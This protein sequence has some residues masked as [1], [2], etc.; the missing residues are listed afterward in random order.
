MKRIEKLRIP[1]PSKKTLLFVV[2]AFLVGIV[3]SG[4]ILGLAFYR[5]GFLY[6]EALPPVPSPAPP[7]L[8]GEVE[9]AYEKMKE[10]PT[11]LETVGRMVIYTA[12]LG[13]EVDDVD[14]MI[15]EIRRI[16][17]DV[18]GF[19][20]GVSTS[21]RDERKVGIITI[22]VPQTDFY[23]IIWQIE[24]LGEVESKE[25]RGED[26][27]EQYIDL[28]ARLNNLQRQEERLLEIL[29]MATTVDEVLR[30]ES[31]LS[32]VRGE[33][34]R[35]TGQIQYLERRVDL[36]TITVSLTESA[37][38]PWIKVPEVD[39]GA[40]IEAGLWGVF[41]VIQG[42]IT[43]VIAAVPFM[44]IGVPAY[45]VYKWRKRTKSEGYPEK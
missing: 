40:P 39:W 21:R 17:E 12:H 25:V 10:A 45:Y 8:P 24:G 13:L 44:A 36:A 33:I 37:P 27:T 1:R 42:I 30:V 38:K 14:S 9:E 2:I 35:L 20:S 26:V 32:R 5:G 11:G 41:L 22:R 19:V 6:R 3:V 4:F 29:A 23:T 15:N 31:E 16:T 34:E 43:L 7:P 28:K 18:G